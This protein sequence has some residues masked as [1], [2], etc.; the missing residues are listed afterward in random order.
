MYRQVEEKLTRLLVQPKAPIILILGLR[1]VGKSTL[2]QTLAKKQEWVRFDFDVLGDRQELSQSDRHSLAFLAQ[3]YQG[4]VVIVDEIQKMPEATAVIKHLYDTYQMKF[5]LTGSSE[6]KIRRGVGDSLV[7]RLHEVRLYPLSLAEINIQ[8]GLDFDPQREFNNYEVN[9]QLLWRYLVYGSLPQLQNIPV[10]QYRQYLDDF[11]NG[12]MSKDVLEVS[13]TRKATKVYLL[14]KLLALQIGQL[15]NFNELASNTEMSRESVYRYVDIFEQLGLIVR[16]RPMSTNERE[17][18]SKRA[19]IYFTDLGVRNSLV[20]NFD[21]WE[22][23]VDK[24]QLLENAVFVGI[25]RARDYGGV[26]TNL[27]FFRSPHG[28]EIDIVEKS[29]T[30]QKLYEVKVGGKGTPGK[31]KVEV[32]SLQIAQKYLY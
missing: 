30:R 14:A 20:G 7:G 5:I 25:K 28:A 10:A 8:S 4:Q 22:M 19:K 11:T 27:G 16:A 6:L 1:Q 21:A 17:A 3:K 18:I 2:A 23:R 13:G 29:G 32:I 9:Q 26:R 24:G 12:L 15:V 31:G